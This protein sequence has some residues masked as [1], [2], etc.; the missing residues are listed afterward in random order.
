MSGTGSY[1]TVKGAVWYETPGTVGNRGYVLIQPPCDLTKA[2]HVSIDTGCAFREVLGWWMGLTV[3]SPCSPALALALWPSSAPRS[4][5]PPLSAPFN[6]LSP[7]YLHLRPPMHLCRPMPPS[8]VLA[9]RV[10][11]GPPSF[12]LAALV[13]TSPPSPLLLSGSSSCGSIALIAIVIVIV[14]VSVACRTRSPCA[15]HPRIYSPSRLLALSHSCPARR[16]VGHPLILVSALRCSCCCCHR[17][18][19][20]L[21]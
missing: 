16:R 11:A 20:Y 14:V 4:C 1:R 2:A 18:S 19:S 8:L 6:R 17:V 5:P 12:V 15:H 9:A 3:T 10:R 13:C 21:P 7:A